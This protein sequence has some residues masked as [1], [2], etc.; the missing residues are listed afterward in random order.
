MRLVLPDDPNGAGLSRNEGI[1][2]D[3]FDAS[4]ISALRQIW[5]RW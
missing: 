5:T 2:K 1:G 4:A 3:N